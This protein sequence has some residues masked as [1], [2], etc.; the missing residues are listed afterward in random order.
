MK[1]NQLTDYFE[2]WEGE[3]S[4]SSLLG[5]SD[6]TDS[7]KASLDAQLDELLEL[8]RP[9]IAMRA[10]PE[11]KRHPGKSDDKKL[12]PDYGSPPPEIF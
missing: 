12:P 7:E 3:D 4:L 8:M 5:R 10:P 2:E 6:L 11:V 1:P 9:K